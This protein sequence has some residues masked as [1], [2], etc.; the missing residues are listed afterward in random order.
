MR[1]FLSTLLLTL[2]SIGSVG[3]REFDVVVYGGTEGGVMA[4][5][6][7]ARAG[8]KVV[9]VTDG[10]FVGGLLGGGQPYIEPEEQL[11]TGGLGRELFQR[12]GKHYGQDL[13]WAAEPHVA[14]GYFRA[15]LRD[16]G[17]EVV[18]E[19]QL[20]DTNSV[21]RKDRR[22][23]RIITDNG[24]VFE[25]A[26][27]IDASYEGDLMAAAGVPFDLPAAEE[28]AQAD[29]YSFVICATASE[30]RAAI[31]KPSDYDPTVFEPWLDFLAA[32]EETN[33]RP[34]GLS[35]IVKATPL[36]FGKEAHLIASGSTGIDYLEADQTRRATIWQNHINYT[37]GLYH[38]LA[39][40]EQAPAAIRTEFLKYGLCEDE[41]L[42]TNRWPHQLR[43]RIGRRMR[44]DSTVTWQD[45]KNPQPDS[46]AVANFN[47]ARFQAPYRVLLPPAKRVRNLLVV[48]C[49]SASA[50]ISKQL[51]RPST[52]MALGHA[53]GLAAKLAID[54]G[55]SVQDI[56][57]GQLTRQLDQ[58][59]AILK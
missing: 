37:T 29:N 54:G 27:Y 7:A 3:A 2:L 10:R 32:L 21:R 41:F 56:D 51:R 25:A 24:E 57:T 16:A 36:P 50:A 5:V 13:V 28:V 8:A 26:V 11:I 31:P 9:L 48:N 46:I 52:A 22:I 49:P 58:Q 1:S 40:D 4:A 47:A 30:S 34:V 44:G 20:R 17:V 18:R 19:E 53:A 38:F 42:F 55:V 35:D 33:G 59:G 15:M 23:R 6:A 14:E 45:I 39:N 43:I 12:I